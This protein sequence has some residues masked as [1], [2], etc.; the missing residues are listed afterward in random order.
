VLS[1]LGKNDSMEEEVWK[2]I[3]GYEGKYQ[4]SNLGRVKSLSRYFSHW[5]GGT[6]KV[7]DKISMGKKKNNGYLYVTLFKNNIRNNHHV[8]RLVANAFLNNPQNKKEVNH[9]DGIKSNNYLSNLE[10][11]TPS[12]NKKHAF[13]LGLW[14]S[15]SFWLGKFGKDHPLSKPVDQFSKDGKFIKR[16]NGLKEA[17]RETGFS[18]KCISSAA[19]GRYKT[20]YG[21]IWKFVDKE[22]LKEVV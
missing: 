6:R 2:D 13:K 21:Y 16:Y 12:E 20:S 8:H 4:V 10:F 22:Q 5:R 1:L 18:F 9:I 3:E 17:H 15:P 14:E 7:Q 19:I 11:V